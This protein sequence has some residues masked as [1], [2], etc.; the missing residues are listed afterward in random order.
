MNKLQT[1]LGR[2]IAFNKIMGREVGNRDHLFLQSQLLVQEGITELSDAVYKQDRTMLR[3]A[4]ADTVVVA[5]GGAYICKGEY[6]FISD[7]FDTDFENICFAV[8]TAVSDSIFREDIEMIAGSFDFTI[9]NA[10][11]Y[12]MLHSI[13]LADDL[14]AVNDSN[15]SKFCKTP[16]EA[17]STIRK[18]KTEY[19]VDSE[20]RAT[21]NDE[22][23]LA[24][25]S[26]KTVG[27]FTKGKL[28]KSINY[29][30]PVF[31]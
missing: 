29:Q 30:E 23:P 25:Y 3:D 6:S 24:V 19:G 21:G 12:A 27:D 14:R 28:L 4:L 11:N 13:D 2:V 18:Y 9:L 10:V 15:F 31:S 16:N 17:L 1:Q 20:Y 22:Y 5:V 8:S 7:E 26:T